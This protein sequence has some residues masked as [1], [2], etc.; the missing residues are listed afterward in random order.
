MESLPLMPQAALLLHGCALSQY[1][2]GINTTIASLAIGV[3]SSGALIYF[4]IVVAGVVSETCPYQTP[5]AHA[6]RSVV[7][8]VLSVTPTI[9]STFKRA[10]GH[11]KVIHMFQVEAHQ[12]RE[13]VMVSLR[14]VPCK[15]LCALAGDI[16]YL[17]QAMVHPLMA[18]ACWMYTWVVCAYSTPNCGL[19]QQT[20]LLDLKC[21][22]WVLNT[23]LDKGIHLSTL[24]FLA[25]IETLVDFN[26]TLVADCF[27]VLTNCVKVIDNNV[28]V[29]QGLEQLATVSAMCLFYTLSHLSVMDPT[30]SVLEDVCQKY[31]TDFKPTTNFKGFSFCHT[32]GAVHS[33]FYAKYSHYEWFIWWDYEPPSHEHV[34]FAHAIA[35]LAQSQY[36]QGEHSEM[37]GWILRFVL[38]FLSSNP[39]PPS[40]VVVDCLSII[41][42]DLGCNISGTRTMTLAERYV[43]F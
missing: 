1:L 43:Y 14:R 37:P 5:G 22:S 9:T 2:W 11:S 41:A 34:I 30:S 18:P 32:L 12:S 42:I 23:S 26:P 7:S 21:I 28:V 19:E 31:C 16:L 24:E 3:T 39:P 10:I 27:N 38:R 40:S 8:G 4:S 13:N 25:T 20:T 36:L 33:V 17:G 35:K 29:T 6:L 15:L